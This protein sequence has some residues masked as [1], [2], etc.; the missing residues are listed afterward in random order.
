MNFDEQAIGAGSD[1]GAG[2]RRH[3]VAA[4]GAVRRIGKH[5]KVRKFLDNGNGRDVKSVAGVSLERANAALAEND[6]VIPARKNV[7]GAHQKFFHG[8]GHAAF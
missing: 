1:G 4:S 2:H 7:F 8:G 6:V 3:F 5:R